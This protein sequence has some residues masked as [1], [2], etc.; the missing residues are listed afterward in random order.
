MK[1]DVVQNDRWLSE[2]HIACSIVS[3]P[4]LGASVTIPREALLTIS[5]IFVRSTLIEQDGEL[6]YT[7]GTQYQ[8]WGI[9]LNDPLTEPLPTSEEYATDPRIF[10]AENDGNPGATFLAVGGCEIHTIMRTLSNMRGTMQE[11]GSI[12]GTGDTISQQI[13]F[14]TGGSLCSAAWNSFPNTKDNTARMIRIDEFGLDLDGNDDGDITC[15]EIMACLFYTSDAA[16][17]MQCV[18]LGGRRHI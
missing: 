8:I 17:D 4:V 7:G 12:I 3:S 6:Q 11:D 10:D 5:P 14:P 18:E 15:D 13:N 16:D 2:T 9:R 1:V